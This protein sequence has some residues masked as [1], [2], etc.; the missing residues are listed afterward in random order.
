MKKNLCLV[1]ITC[2][3]V[4]GTFAYADDSA[5]PDDPSLKNLSGIP[6]LE[7][8][9][10]IKDP[11]TK[12]KVSENGSRLIATTITNRSDFPGDDLSLKWMAPK[13][14]YCAD[15]TYPIKPGSNPNHDVFWAYRTLKHTYKGKDFTCN[16][17]WTVQVINNTTGQTLATQHYTVD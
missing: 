9:I 15:S 2:M 17:I 11:S 8:S 14:S 3:A 5:A 13:H 16:G 1:L 4:A 10:Q 6:P 12:L 7:K